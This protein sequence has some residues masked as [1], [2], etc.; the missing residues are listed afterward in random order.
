MRIPVPYWSFALVVFS[1]VVW[2]KIQAQSQ[3]W[4]SEVHEVSTSAICSAGYGANTDFYGF[5][6]RLGFYFQWVSSWLLNTFSP[7]DANANHD[8]NSNLVLAT[9]IAIA[10]A[11]AND[12]IKPVEAYI[13]FMTCFGFYFTV[14]SS[15][16]IRIFFLD[17][18]KLA[19]FLSEVKEK[20]EPWLINGTKWNDLKQ[21]FQDLMDNS[22]SWRRLDGL[23]EVLKLMTITLSFNAASFVKHPSLSWA[24]V[25]WRAAIASLVAVLNIWLWFSPWMIQHETQDDGSICVPSVYFFGQQALNRTI[26]TFFKAAAVILA[27]PAFF[28]FLLFIKVAKTLLNFTY[29]FLLRHVTISLVERGTAIPWDEL[30]ERVKCMIGL[31]ISS[32]TGNYGGAGWAAI[33]M[34]D[35][36]FQPKSA[37]ATGWW[38]VNKIDLPS[39]GDLVAAHI[40]L[41]SRADDVDG[42]SDSGSRISDGSQAQPKSR[43]GSNLMNSRLCAWLLTLLE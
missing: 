1:A 8:A 36:L 34:L 5:G 43:F 14:L 38:T 28:L 30:P 3:L 15:L 19:L 31:V 6:I 22:A 7:K 2:P 21:R 40:A 33:G 18:E 23:K 25:M 26:N 37:S 12:S 10:V 16:G 11:F 35:V 20:V 13:M 39:V 42:S 9:A 4:L 24:G 29:Y 32:A 27:I 41:W 17:P